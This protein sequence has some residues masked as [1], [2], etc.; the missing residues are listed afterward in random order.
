MKSSAIGLSSMFATA[1]LIVPLLAGVLFFHQP[2]RMMQILGLIMFFVAA[3]LLIG[4][5]KELFGKFTVK[6]F[7]ILVAILL[8]NGGTML[9]QQLFTQYV[10]DGDI[11]VFSFLAFALVSGL[12]FVIYIILKPADDC[13]NSIT[14]IS[15]KAFIVN[16]MLLA[17]TLFILNQL[18]T[19][20]TALVP[21][22]VLFTFSSGGGT[23]ASTVVAA[24]L[25]NEKLSVKSVVGIFLG[26]ISLII[27]IL[28]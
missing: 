22:V 20:L 9:A 13:K 6:T 11:S 17:V 2:V 8:A 15:K 5:S 19:F 18:A 1:G 7:V 24:I 3:W 14:D 4:S 23:I 21:P 25:Y 16:G 28:Y 12:G 27:I 26:I 10:P